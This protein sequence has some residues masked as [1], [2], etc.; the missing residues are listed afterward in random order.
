MNRP[1]IIVDDKIPFLTGVLEPYANIKYMPGNQIKRDS[2]SNADALLIRTRTKCN[3]SLLKGT[4]VKFIATATIGYDHID[5]KYCNEQKI[6][7]ANAPGCNS[8]SVQQY[9]VAALLTLAEKNNFSLSDKTIGIVGVGNVGSKVYAAAKLLGLNVKLNDPPRAKIERSSGFVSLD[10]IVQTSDII[11]LHVPLNKEDP[12]KTFHL[13]DKELLGKM[14]KNSWL[15]NSSRGEVVETS[16]LKTAL[17]S[18]KLQGAV[19]DVWEN[20]PNIDTELL[21]LVD[22][23]T[24]HIAG[25]SADGKANGTAQVVRSLSNY[26]GFPL[27]NFYPNRLPPPFNPTIFVDAGLKTSEHV[28][29]EVVFHTYPIIEDHQKLQQSPEFFEQQRSQNN[30]RREFP[31]YTVQISNGCMDEWKVLHDLGFIVKTL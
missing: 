29:K 21:R 20:E 9:L 17:I 13:F 25:Y 3:Q 4:S 31:A 6:L 15:I 28:F 24:P 10:E 12:Y 7:W 5:T 30:W 1:R 18:G 8:S 16:A 27:G 22:I 26:F 14:K 11:T 19:L 2:I 23:S